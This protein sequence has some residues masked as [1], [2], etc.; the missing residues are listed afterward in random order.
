[1]TNSY[2]KDQKMSLLFLVLS[3]IAIFISSLGLFGLATFTTQSRIKEI[4]IRKINGAMISEIFLKYNYEL[5]I[6][7]I[8][9]F[10][11][12]APVGYYAMNKWLSNF[13]YKTNISFLLLAVSGLLAL[14]IGLITVSW[15][16]NKASR[17]NPA[18]TLRKE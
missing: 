9:S 5:L 18:E 4:S 1:M 3:V 10:I 6:W 8:I 7:I 15:A 13:A 17:T 11:I 12:A 16:A 2:S 14:A